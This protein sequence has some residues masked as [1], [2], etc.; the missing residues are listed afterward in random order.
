MSAGSGASAELV[1]YH[2][3]IHFEMCPLSSEMG[4]RMRSSSAVALA[5]AG[6]TDKGT[7]KSSMQDHD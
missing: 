7:T 2:L 4:S 1:A 6:F 5:P 3:E